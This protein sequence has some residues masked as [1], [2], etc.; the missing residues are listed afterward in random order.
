MEEQ[1]TSASEN[2]ADLNQNSATLLGGKVD[3]V[4]PN[5][6]GVLSN[7]VHVEG[8]NEDRPRLSELDKQTLDSIADMTTSASQDTGFGSA[9]VSEV[10]SPL[11][12]SGGVGR[13][14]D[15]TAESETEAETYD[16][17]VL[18]DDADNDENTLNTEASY[19]DV[20]NDLEAYSEGSEHTQKSVALENTNVGNEV[21]GSGV[22]N[23]ASDETEVEHVKQASDILVDNA[24]KE[25][26][27]DHIT[28]SEQKLVDSAN[29]GSADLKQS[30]NENVDNAAINKV[31]D[32]NDHDTINTSLK[33]QNQESNG[34]NS[35]E[36][37][38]NEVNGKSTDN[39]VEE[40]NEN[41]MDSAND[42]LKEKEDFT[43]LK[44]AEFEK[45]ASSD[46]ENKDIEKET[47]VI[48]HNVE[49]EKG[50][51]YEA[52]TGGTADERKQYTA[53]VKREQH[54]AAD[55]K[56]Q[57][58]VADERVSE[59]E[60]LK[61]ADEREQTVA[62]ELEQQTAVDEIEQH[63]A[64]DDREQHT[65]ADYKEQHTADD[66]IEQHTA[67][68]VLTEVKKTASNED[69][70]V[71]SVLAEAADNKAEEDKAASDEEKGTMDILGNG[72]LKK[73][74][75]I[76][77]KG[78]HTRPNNGDIVTV[79][80]D[81]QLPDGTHVDTGEITFNLNDGDVI[82]AFDLAVALMEQGETCELYTSERYAYG[83]LGREPDIPKD[84]S[85]TYT[86]E[87]VNIAPS[88][89]ITEMSYDQRLKIGEAKR[90]RGNYLFGRTDYSGA[91][92]SYTRAVKLLD[93][94]ELN[95][96]IDESC[97]SVLTESWVKC[98][99]N[100]AA[101]QLKI[102]AVDSAI[103]SCEKVLSVQKDNVK[104]L[105]RLG[106]AYGV[107][108]EVDDAI[109]Y[110][111]RALKLEPESK[112]MQQEMLN[113]TRR[114]NKETATEKELYQ[115]MLGVRPGEKSLAE[116]DKKSNSNKLVKW[117]LVAGGVAAVLISVGLTWYR[118]S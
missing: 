81:G 27:E 106:K 7:G 61:V 22:E 118:A 97:R 116:E 67:T 13:L 82:L 3:I 53:T 6:N 58:T 11:E 105:F 113:L 4:A 32:R 102:D 83:S 12:C 37:K 64:A 26:A 24:V 44:E 87:L 19:E 50:T 91:I 38:Y 20:N 112:L 28:E 36:T 57:D 18:G 95:D 56:E 46:T 15:L 49:T 117:T 111:R 114:K 10:S 21:K 2:F 14:Q 78:V 1:S 71:D 94:P 45:P 34:F 70:K 86:L 110:I 107:K 79:K 17:V 5:E 59:R 60:Q 109:G 41:V 51:D 108:G 9:S 92:N 16:S 93:N 47:N 90:E 101:C 29:V 31:V 85:I 25:I 104:A 75:L 103:K 39:V 52:K 54:T 76:A 73:K 88:P 84:T 43:N 115:R 80:V 30:E 42:E 35:F 33:G 48:T 72:L 96:G 74:V 69:Q 98:Y 40:V 23:I 89:A 8:K 62:R 55:E 100:L 68:D 77:G 63:T 99:N 66:E 65:A